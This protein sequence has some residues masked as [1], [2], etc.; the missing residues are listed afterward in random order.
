MGLGLPVN[1]KMEFTESCIPEN[2]TSTIPSPVAPVRR[3]AKSFSVATSSSNSS[4]V[5]KGIFINCTSLIFVVGLIGFVNFI[6]W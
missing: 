6:C 3:L 1:I 4:N 5:Q 2:E